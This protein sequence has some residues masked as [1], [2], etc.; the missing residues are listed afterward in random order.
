MK[1]NTLSLDA[2]TLKSKATSTPWSFFIASLAGL[3]G[4]WV[5]RRVLRHSLFAS[6]M[7]ATTVSA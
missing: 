2:Q 5:A 4:F 3:A 1:L 7:E 6:M